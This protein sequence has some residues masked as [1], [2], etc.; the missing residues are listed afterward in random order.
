MMRA[1]EQ[2]PKQESIQIE[3]SIKTFGYSVKFDV[4]T[5]RKKQINRLYRN[6]IFCHGWTFKKF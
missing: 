4:R 6:V 3:I 2:G 1:A 5:K